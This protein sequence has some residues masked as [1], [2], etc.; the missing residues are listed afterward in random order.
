M[1]INISMNNGDSDAMDK[2]STGDNLEDAIW[3]DNRVLQ[4]Q[5]KEKD[6]RRSTKART[7]I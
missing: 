6:D 7:P 3:S 5:E 1:T 2:G 4:K